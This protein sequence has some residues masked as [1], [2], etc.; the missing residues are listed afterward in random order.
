MVHWNT[1]RRKRVWPILIRYS[2]CKVNGCGLN[3]WDSILDNLTKSRPNIEPTKWV[4]G[5][6]RP[7]REANHSPLSS[8]EIQ[9]AWNFTSTP[10]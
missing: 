10:V 4:L 6:N 1:N 8:A 2:D 9:N 5:V 7:V 3:D